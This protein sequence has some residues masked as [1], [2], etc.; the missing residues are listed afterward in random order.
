MD[1][2]TNFKCHFHLTRKKVYFV[3]LLIILKEVLK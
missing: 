3:E 2:M 1:F